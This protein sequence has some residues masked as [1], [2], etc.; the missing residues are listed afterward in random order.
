MRVATEHCTV[1]IKTDA[2]LANLRMF[3]TDMLPK[4]VRPAAQAGAQVFYDEVRTRVAAMGSGPEKA[5][6]EAGIQVGTGNLLRSIYQ[7]YSED[8][9]GPSKAAYVISWR[10]GKAKKGAGGLTIAPHGHLVELGHRRKYKVYKRG[11]RWYTR[12]R[13]EA[14]G[15]KVK[16]IGLGRFRMIKDPN[17]N[18]LTKPNWRA[19]DA[20]MSQYFDPLPGGKS[21]WQRVPGK[22]FIRGSYEA[23]KAAATAAMIQRMREEF[24]RVMSG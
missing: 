5:A 22:A 23:K 2:L 13:P 4:L 15:Y 17:G 21:G 9:S 24:A 19:G 7:A 8:K 18:R 10:T 6:A 12:V 20:V 11:G 16:Y 14:I 3:A 1:D